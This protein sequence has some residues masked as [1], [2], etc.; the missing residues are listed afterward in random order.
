MSTKYANLRFG[1]D[2]SKGR[3]AY[4]QAGDDWQV[5]VDETGEKLWIVNG[6][7]STTGRPRA[8]TVE[9]TNAQAAHLARLLLQAVALKD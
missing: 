8:L 7:V 3:P 2:A 1:S 5:T 9:F 4:H 6:G